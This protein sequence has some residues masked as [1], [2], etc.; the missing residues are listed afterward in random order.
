MFHLLLLSINRLNNT[1]A[2]VFTLLLHILLLVDH[3]TIFYLYLLQQALSVCVAAVK[4]RPV[5]HPQCGYVYSFGIILCNLLYLKLENHSV[6]PFITVN[7]PSAVFTLLFHL[8]LP[9]DHIA[10]IYLCVDFCP[11]ICLLIYCLFVMML[12]GCLSVVYPALFIYYL[13]LYCSYATRRRYIP[14]GKLYR[15]LN[16]KLIHVVFEK[17]CGLFT[18][19]LPRSFFL[20]Q[21]QKETVTV[22]NMYRYLFHL[23]C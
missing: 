18:I 3:M 10:R 1:R 16:M 19:S 17:Q 5:L 15:T 23:H 11:L 8:W 21:Y 4:S 7:E 12:L 6:A 22:C 9:R 13:L 14:T 2:A 20:S